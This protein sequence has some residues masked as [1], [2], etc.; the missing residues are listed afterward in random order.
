MTHADDLRYLKQEL[1]MEA[2]NGIL[3]M[4]NRKQGN[5]A[6]RQR[7]RFKTKDQ[8]ELQEGHDVHCMALTV[9]AAVSRGQGLHP[10]S[11]EL[12]P[13]ARTNVPAAQ[14][15]H[16]AQVR[17]LEVEENAVASQSSHTLGGWQSRAGHSVNTQFSL[18]LMWPSTVRIEV[19]MVVW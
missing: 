19:T 5:Q 12:V 14:S 9:G 4:Y 1:E 15:V 17:A 2:I 8:P 6:G 13:G 16:E 10:R 18:R 11:V 3:Y 7:Y